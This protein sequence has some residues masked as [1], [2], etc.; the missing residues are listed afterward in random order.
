M[1]LAWRDL[2]ALRDLDH[3]DA[4]LHRILV[5]CIYRLAS[6]ERRQ[7]DRRQLIPPLDQSQSDPAHD[8]ENRDQIDRGFRRLPADHRA[9]LVVHYYLGLPDDA[10][11]GMLGI[12]VGT[13]KSR[14]HRATVA[15][16]AELEA[17]MRT[18]D[19]APTSNVP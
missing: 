17:E 11:A 4:W 16:R 1:I 8:L 19:R 13:F 9:A 14:L 15:L 3:F 5:R 7:A 18:G 6:S 12:A 2:K 10:A